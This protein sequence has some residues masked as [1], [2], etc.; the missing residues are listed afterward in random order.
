MTC[1]VRK[2]EILDIHA[3]IK[4]Q[5]QCTHSERQATPTLTFLECSSILNFSKQSHFRDSVSSRSWYASLASYPNEWKAARSF[6]SNIV[7]TLCVGNPSCPAPR[8]KWMSSGL[9]AK[10]YAY[11]LYVVPKSIATIT[12][13]FPA[14]YRYFAYA[15]SGISSKLKA[16]L[17]SAPSGSF[18][19]VLLPLPLSFWVIALGLFNNFS[20]NTLSR[21]GPGLGVA[22]FKLPRPL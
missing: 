3:L 12:F 7:G 10:A 14:A 2:L 20:E 13:G 21:P 8:I 17:P 15:S 11:P 18:L 4:S 19:D 6:I 9:L 16:V 1:T 22:I 5:P